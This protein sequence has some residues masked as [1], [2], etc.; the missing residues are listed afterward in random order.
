MAKGVL[1]TDDS[2]RRI[3]AVV[4][5]Q[6]RTVPGGSH[7]QRRNVGG[8][9]KLVHAILI[10]YTAVGTNRFAYDWVEAIISSIGRYTERTG[11][12]NSTTH[13]LAYNTVENRNDGVGV[14]SSVN[15]DG[16]NYPEGFYLQPIRGND[17]SGGNPAP[18][19]S[20]SW[21]AA[22]GPGVI[23]MRTLTDDYTTVWTFTAQNQHDGTCDSLLTAGASTIGVTCG[24][25]IG[26][27][28]LA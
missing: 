16:A 3:A 9:P 27:A 6:E 8:A 28:W 2:A 15:V 24:S 4:R 22:V 19:A 14:E 21:A 12:L 5:Q 7:R 25:D 1:F 20:G 18:G 26:R 17:W 10:G 23:L 13:G 11:G